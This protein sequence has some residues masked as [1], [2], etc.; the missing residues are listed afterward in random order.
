[1]NPIFE[2]NQQQDAHEL[3]VC[4]LD[5]IRETFQLLVKQRERQCSQT[6]GTTSDLTIDNPVDPQLENNSGKRNLRKS[7]KKK[8]ATNAGKL[9]S[10]SASQAKVNGVSAKPLENGH[11]ENAS[12]SNSNSLTCGQNVESKKCFISEDFE[13]V[14]LLRTTCL[15]CEHITERKET[16]CDICV[17]I[18]MD[19]TTEKGPLLLTIIFYFF[20]KYYIFFKYKSCGVLIFRLDFSL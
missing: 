4:L 6:N 14:S 12:E 2:G 17:P 19:R 3:L 18:E 7:W 11:S 20:K 5:N 9:G 10:S 13:G 16:F 8:K 15:E 1:M